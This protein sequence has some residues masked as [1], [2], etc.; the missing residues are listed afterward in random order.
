MMLNEGYKILILG[1]T[2]FVGKN[3]VEHLQFAKSLIQTTRKA[4]CAINGTIFFDIE[5]THSWETLK[6]IQPDSIINCIG[7]GVVKTQRETEKVYDIN[8]FKT[9]AFYEY[10]SNEM[11]EVN[12]VHIGT[13]FEYDLSQVRLTETSKAL[14]FTHYGISKLM[15]SNYLLQKKIKNPFLIVRPF[16]MF[17]L[18]E[19][20]SKIVPSLI[21]SQ[22]NKIPIELSSGLQR[23]D[24]S[25]VGDFA[26]FIGKLIQIENF[27]Q[28]PKS[29]NVG[30]GN[31]YS[32]K[33]L[34]IKIAD[35]LPTYD[36]SL[37]NWNALPQRIGEYDEFY[38]GSTLAKE[39]GFE[40]NTVETNI[41]NTIQYYWNT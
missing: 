39:L 37:W 8:Y 1:A 21:L 15:T 10:L 38:N 35:Y 13:A 30:T 19:D 5:D 4:E 18:Y 22:K 11:P 27:A 31:T 14:P 29:I 32:I 12:I 34:S 2:G 26:K 28:L 6:D 3:I 36:A 16:N 40:W 7:Y 20:E 33:E 23:R 17:G 24:Y 41:K 9:V 25:Y